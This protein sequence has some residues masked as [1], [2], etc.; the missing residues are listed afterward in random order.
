MSV[1]YTFPEWSKD[2]FSVLG[3]F[4]YFTYFPL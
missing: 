3:Y 4:V 2:D 1:A